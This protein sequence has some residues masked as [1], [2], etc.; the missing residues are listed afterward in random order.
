MQQGDENVGD[1]TV[2]DRATSSH[3]DATELRTGDAAAS[4][5]SG[6]ET[7][8]VST[9]PLTRRGNVQKCPV[10]GSD[11]EAEA[12]H[13]PTCLNYFC[14]HCRAR[15]LPHDTQLQCVSQQCDYYG[16]LICC[17]CDVAEEQDEPP[18][19]YSE[20]EDGYWPAWLVIVLAACGAV[21]YFS[22]FLFAAAVAA[23]AFGVG[24]FLLHRAGFNVFGKQRRVE[25]QRKSSI[26]KCLQCGQ[27]A[28]EIQGVQK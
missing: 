4:D 14:F 6:D 10:C 25:H 18:A 15:V 8:V 5:A 22:S 11:V 27:T 9:I 17:V 20:P 16:K 28:K 13:C 24:G 3:S 1:K 7:D 12:F 19:V 2:E 26:H 23:S 21:W